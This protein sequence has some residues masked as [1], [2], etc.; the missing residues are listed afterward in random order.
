MLA[1]AISLV[2]ARRRSVQR[3]LFPGRTMSSSHGWTC[4]VFGRI[5]LSVSNVQSHGC[6]GPCT[7]RSKRGVLGVANFSCCS[8]CENCDVLH[9]GSEACPSHFSCPRRRGS[10]SRQMNGPFH[11]LESSSTNNRH[12]AI[13]L[14]T[15]TYAL[16][17]GS[18][19]RNAA[20]IPGVPTN[21]RSIHPIWIPTNTYAP[22]Q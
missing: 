6:L 15:T 18:S 5:P 2:H 3:V 7:R 4:G 12:P 1:A 8:R 13:N 16:L 19:R 14:S 17:N 21:G 10:T 9:W 11:K 22:S 20:S